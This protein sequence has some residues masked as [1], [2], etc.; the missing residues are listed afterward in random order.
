MVA[1]V[2]TVLDYLGEVGAAGALWTAL[3]AGGHELARALEAV[4]AA[5]CVLFAGPAEVPE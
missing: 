3:D 4:C 5:N 2:A 1:R